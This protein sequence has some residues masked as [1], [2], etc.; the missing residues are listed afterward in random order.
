[1]VKIWKLDT[2]GKEIDKT[3]RQFENSE[4]ERIY[5]PL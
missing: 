3:L 4:L 1:M 5:Q 2:K